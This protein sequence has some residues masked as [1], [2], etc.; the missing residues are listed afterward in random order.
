MKISLI[1]DKI[2]QKNKI[3]DEYDLVIN[4]DDCQKQFIELKKRLVVFGIFLDTVDINPVENCDLGLFVNMPERDNEYFKQIVSLNKPAYVIVNE[5]TLIHP[6]N[7]SKEMGDFFKKIFTYQEEKIDNQRIFKINYSFDFSQKLNNFK[8]LPFYDKKL[9]TLIAGYKKLD[10]PLELYSER[11]KTIRWFE[12]HLS[13]DFDL[14]GQGWNNYGF[15]KNLVARKFSSYRGSVREKQEVLSNYKFSICY[16]NAKNIPGWI[17][18]KIF[19]S[20]F[21]GSV[22]VYW[23]WQGVSEYIPSNCFIDRED[24]KNNGELGNFLTSLSSNDYQIYTDNIF[25]F[26]CSIRSDNNYQF[27]I[28]YFVNTIEREILKDFNNL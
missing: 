13:S 27:S 12:R 3:F 20:F 2:Y 22:P 19:D 17:T 26:L 1:V 5:L 9:C 7:A 4:R 8:L 11:I 18:E 25:N 24:F 23:G 21:A 10:H 15:L 14:Y 16:E 6:Q 28:P